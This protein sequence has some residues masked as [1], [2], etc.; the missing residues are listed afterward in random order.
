[1]HGTTIGR[2]H[3]FYGGPLY[4]RPGED[5]PPGPDEQTTT[6]NQGQ[7]CVFLRRLSR[8]PCSWY[9]FSWYRG[10]GHPFGAC[11]SPEVVAVLVSK[12]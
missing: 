11:R 10:W 1:M 3:G 5:T 7:R 4:S 2:P 8:A 12:G 9:E 6:K